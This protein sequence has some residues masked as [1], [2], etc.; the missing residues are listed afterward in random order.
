MTNDIKCPSCGH[1]F[2]AEN[3]LAADIEKKL[4][5]QYQNKFQ[6]LT[7]KVEVEKKETRSRFNFI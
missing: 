2:D 4:K 1:V 6:E 3:V 7:S 5:G